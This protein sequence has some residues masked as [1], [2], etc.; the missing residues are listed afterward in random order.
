MKLKKSIWDMARPDVET[1]RR[2]PKMPVVLVLDNIRSLNN[3]GSMF[4]T[5]DAFAVEGLALCGV[6]GTPPAPEIHKTALGAE[7]SV[8][9]KYYPDTLTALRELRQAAYTLCALELTH[10][11][12]SLETFV[13]APGGRYAIV[14]GN[15]VDGVAQDVV[16]ACDFCLEIPQMGTKHSLNV[17]VSASLALWHLF[18]TYLPRLKSKP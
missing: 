18:Q 8:A 1:F 12:V 5:S 2:A 11:S 17:A 4:R 3:I 9:W 7:D 15:E 10:G 16:D 13:P 14:V 6:T